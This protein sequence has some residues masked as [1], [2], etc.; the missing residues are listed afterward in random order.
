MY[1]NRMK[2]KLHNNNSWTTARFHSFIK[3]ALR[4]AVRRWGP[5][6]SVKRTAWQSR[7]RYLC[8]GYQ[9]LAHE[10]PLTAD[11]K[12]NIAVDHINPVINP[13]TGFQTWDEVVAR[14]FVEEDGLQVLCR[15]CHSKKTADERKVRKNNNDKT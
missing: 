7:G 2:P 6:H 10:V 11:K 15:D 5:I 4:Q 1:G 8:A 3:G 13:A 14:M 12:A 9:R